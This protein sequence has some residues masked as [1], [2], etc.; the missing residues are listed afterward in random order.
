MN[1]EASVHAY[2]PSGREKEVHNNL[3]GSSSVGRASS[4]LH[5]EILDKLAN[6]VIT[7]GVKQ[8]AGVRIPPSPAL[9]VDA[10]ALNNEAT[11]ARLQS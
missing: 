11:E 3:W 4:L 8:E 2:N 6:G 1:N 5:R 7:R 9:F 10:K